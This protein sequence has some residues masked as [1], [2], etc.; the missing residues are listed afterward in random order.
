MTRIKFC[1]DE[2]LIS[3]KANFETEYYPLY[4]AGD[5]EGIQ[6]LFESEE[7]YEGDLEFNYKQLKMSSETESPNELF[8]ENAK[9]VYSILSELTTAQATREELWFTLLNT[10]FLDYL[11][12]YVK[13][14]KERKDALNKVR[15]MFFNQGNKRSL[16]VNHLAKYWW[17]GYKTYDTVEK[18]NPYW[19]TD[20]FTN[21]DAAG[22]AVLFFSSNITNNPSFTLGIIE[23][24]K[25]LVE[26]GFVTNSKYTYNFINKHFN[27]VGG[28]KVLD[29]M[30]RDQVKN[31]VIAL[32]RDLI[33][34]KIDIQN[35]ERVQILGSN[36]KYL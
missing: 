1:S 13:F 4:L 31:E 22:K 7:V 17:T 32:I 30:T 6:V 36:S 12:D 27:F 35:S 21:D 16:Y 5:K 9:L 3:F 19:L 25:E 34:K 26:D 2:F 14:V 23:A 28:V 11:L 15:N 10:V 20:F 29:I 33:D 18:M 8:K 24:V